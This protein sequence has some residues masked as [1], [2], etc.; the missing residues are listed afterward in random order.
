MNK[1]IFLDRDGVI[2]FSK[3]INGKPY[4][5][6]SLA[7]FKIIPNVKK[8]LQLFK[9]KG[10]L[11]IIIT[12]Q[13]DVARMKISLENINEFHRV[14]KKLLPITEI[15]TCFHDDNDNCECRKPK[16]GKILDAVKKYNIDTSIS[17]MIGDR[18]KDIEAGKNAGCKT[19]FIDYQY[20]EKQ[21]SNYNFKVKSIYEAAE[22]ILNI[23]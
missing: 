19:V 4:A 21:P 7:E 6:T 18:W 14:I 5:P 17:Y 10:Y 23:V 12:N 9:N 13:P 1:A 20:K 16:P 2:N 11:L 3:I 8:A 22:I 15:F